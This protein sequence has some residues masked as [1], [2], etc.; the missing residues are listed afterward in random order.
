MSINNFFELSLLN[1]SKLAV[2]IEALQIELHENMNIF[3]DI[4]K[5][6]HT[7]SHIIKYDV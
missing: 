3:E 5:V 1:K 6:P 2:T 7:Y 4:L